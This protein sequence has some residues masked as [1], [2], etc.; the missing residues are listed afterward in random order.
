ML[1]DECLAQLQNLPEKNLAVELLEDE[2][3]SRFAGAVMQDKKFSELLAGVI[4]R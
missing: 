4:Q 1:I 2:I 3:K